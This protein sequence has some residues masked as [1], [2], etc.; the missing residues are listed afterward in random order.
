M[1]IA[2][3]GSHGTGKSTLVEVLQNRPELIGHS[4]YDGIGRLVHTG[5]KKDWSL[6][7]KQRVFNRWYVWNHYWSKNFVG[8][9]SI[10]DTYAY[11][12]IMVGP[13]FNHRLY[14]WA[15]RHI[16]YDYLFYLPIEFPLEDDGVRYGLEIQEQHDRETR[17]ILD[18]HH[19][20]YHT[21]T[22]SV[23]DRVDQ[24]AAILGFP[25]FEGMDKLLDPKHTSTTKL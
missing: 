8:S 22:G 19:I 3:V 23:Q 16:Y 2:F 1:R 6:K 25:S 11:S 5:V 10:F 15:I 21:L 14:S 12:R 17:L 7:R 13:W 18:Y 9:R 4:I 24:M 20:P